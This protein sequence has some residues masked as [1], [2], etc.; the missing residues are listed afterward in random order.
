MDGVGR[1]PEAVGE[2]GQDADLVHG[3]VAVNIQGRFGL[4]VTLGLGIAQDVGEI[5]LLR[6]HAAEDVIAGA[7]DDAVEVGDAVAHETFAQGFDDGDAAGD[8]GFVIEVRL[9]AFG[10]GEQFLAMGR[11]QGLVGGDHRFAE[12]EG[13]EDHLTGDGGA[14]GQLRHHLDLGILDHRP[15][16]GGH[17]PFRDL[18]LAGFVEG[19]DGDSRDADA[20][21]EPG[22]VAGPLRCQAWKTPPPTVPPPIKPK[23]TCCIGVERLPW[24]GAGDN[25]FLEVLPGMEW[26]SGGEGIRCGRLFKMS[27]EHFLTLEYQFRLAGGGI[28][29]FRIRL[30]EPELQLVDEREAPCRTGRG[31]SIISARIVRCRR[32]STPIVRWRRAWRE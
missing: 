28:K 29:E 19:F 24:A 4:G 22:G 23:L 30:R 32:T 1:N 12:A 25:G 11:E 13:G 20:D 26:K 31:W 16:I 9:V 18:D 5:G 3:I 21:A 14:A 27:A 8:A 15:P 10:G 6:L 2:R 7:V 17:Q